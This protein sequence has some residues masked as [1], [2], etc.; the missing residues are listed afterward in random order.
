VARASALRDWLVRRR[1]IFLRN[2]YYLASRQGLL[3]AFGGTL[4][5]VTFTGP[6]AAEVIA[7]ELGVEYLPGEDVLLVKTSTAGQVV[8]V[9]PSFVA[10]PQPTTGQAPPDAVNGVFNRWRYLPRLGGFAYLPHG[11]ANFWFLATE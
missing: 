11:N 2:I 5:D 10:T 3:L 6:A 7:P 4:S 9:D 8:H 1:V